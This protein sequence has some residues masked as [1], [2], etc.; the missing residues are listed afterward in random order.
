[1]RSGRAALARRVTSTLDTD[2]DHE[3]VVYGLQNVRSLSDKVDDVIELRRDRS[4]DVSY[5]VET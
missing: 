4:I 1:M 2:T 5:L 3:S